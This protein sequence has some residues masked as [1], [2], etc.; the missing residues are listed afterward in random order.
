MHDHIQVCAVSSE[1]DYI[2]QSSTWNSYWQ[3]I[4][5]AWVN[6]SL[7]NNRE[8]ISSQIAYNDLSRNAVKE[9]SSLPVGTYIFLNDFWLF[10]AP[11]RLT[12]SKKSRKEGPFLRLQITNALDFIM[13]ACRMQKQH[14]KLQYL[15]T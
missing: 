3:H 2:V 14:M 11:Y 12:I 7:I 6:D 13:N 8:H 9:R 1:L 10:Y 4:D 15:A 5:I